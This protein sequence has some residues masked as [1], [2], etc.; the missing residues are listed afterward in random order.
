MSKHATIT[1]ERA[2]TTVHVNL[3]NGQLF[4]LLREGPRG[5]IDVF[6][7]GGAP[8]TLRPKNGWQNSEIIMFPIVGKAPGP[9]NTIVIDG[10]SF[11]MSQH[12]LSRLL[13]WKASFDPA[14]SSLRL[15]QEYEAGQKVK[16]AKGEI[17]EFPR[18]F[19]IVKTISI[20][21][22]GKVKVAIELENLSEKPLPFLVGWH[23]AFVI[24]I[25]AGRITP[26]TISDSI[27][28]SSVQRAEGNVIVAQNS[29][30]ITYETPLFALRMPHTFGKA[31]FWNME[32][33]YV[34]L[35]PISAMSL[36]RAP[37]VTAD[38]SQQEGVKSIPPHQML[39]YEAVMEITLRNSS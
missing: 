27:S 6:W 9:E 10:E 25:D 23:P 2:G 30:T 33:S 24:P 17:S 13:P 12:G 4:R 11:S 35:E 1:I 28:V 14:N 18:S 20:D 39:R 36:S 15:V 29:D 16:N 26:S 8:E 32:G 3:E 21:D 5:R 38:L 19:R 7:S 31:Q 34:A 37:N 22:E